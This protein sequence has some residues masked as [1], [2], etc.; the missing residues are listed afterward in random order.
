MYPSDKTQ[1]QK[2]EGCGV[3]GTPPSAG[4][5][6]ARLVLPRTGVLCAPRGPR[7]PAASL[8]RGLQDEDPDRPRVVLPT[9]GCLCVRM[10][11]AAK[12]FVAESREQP[13][14]PA[15]SVYPGLKTSKTQQHLFLYK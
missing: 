9:S 8:G 1:T 11:M 12:R 7:G 3:M 15:D 10:F 6:E 5:L 13:R 14:R 2:Q 4:A